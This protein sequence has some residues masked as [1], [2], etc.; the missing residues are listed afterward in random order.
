MKRIS[1]T[2]RDF[3]I[4][5]FRIKIP[6]VGNKEIKKDKKSSFT[7]RDRQELYLK[8][9]N[10]VEIQQVYLKKD[11]SLTYLSKVLNTNANYLSKAVNSIGNK[12]FIDFIH[13]YRIEYAKKLLLDE[14]YSKYTIQTI[15]EKSGFRSTS[16]FYKAFRK[17]NSISPGEFL[18]KSNL[19]KIT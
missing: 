9:K 13:E 5:F 14:N 4:S 16:A 2:S 11:V 8:L 18:K 10:Y 15:S 19:S 6:F 12:S 1:L 7:N 17:Q 3:Y